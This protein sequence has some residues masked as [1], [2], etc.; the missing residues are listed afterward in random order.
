MKLLVGRF[1]L[2]CM[3]AVLVLADDVLVDVSTDKPKTSS[4]DTSTTTITPNITVVDIVTE[5][6][7]KSLPEL[8]QRIAPLETPSTTLAPSV[9]GQNSKIYPKDQVD[10][11][12]VVIHE[13]PSGDGHHHGDHGHHDHQGYHDHHHGHDH[14]YHHPPPPPRQP[15]MQHH[16]DHHH[17][18]PHHQHYPHQPYPGYYPPPN[19]PPYPHGMSQHY[20][21]HGAVAPP[22]AYPYYPP[23][24]YYNNSPPMKPS[25]TIIQTSSSTSASTQNFP[26]P[27]DLLNQG[28]EYLWN[29][30]GKLG[31]V[32]GG[33]FANGVPLPAQVFFQT[34]RILNTEK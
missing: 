1:V 23:P 17:P 30:F 5:K 24:V 9:P 18:P 15:P 28:T 25:A 27:G 6:V 11:E 2:G 7:M 20:G 10:R 8:N 14:D 31:R 34:K 26:K 32:E 33:A 12:I 19:Y 21:S 16:H 13:K 22:P 29:L 4:P 3:L